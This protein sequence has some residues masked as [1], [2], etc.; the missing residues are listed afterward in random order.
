MAKKTKK[1]EDATS[2]AAKQ[3][4][5]AVSEF[6]S[7]NRHLLGFDNPTKAL[8]TTVREAVD[9]ALDAC[10]EAEILPTIEVQIDDLENNRYRVSITDNGPGILKNQLSR[11]FGQ[12]LYGSKFHRLKQS[13]GQQGIGISA[14]VMYGQMTTGQPSVVISKT[15]KG[16]PAHRM[17]LQ[18]DTKKNKAKVLTDDITTEAPWDERVSGTSISVILEGNYKGGKHGIDSYLRQTS[19]ANP[20]AEVIFISPKGERSEYPRV[21]QVLPV[22]PEEIKPHPYGVELGTLMR[23]LQDA[24]GQTVAAFLKSSFSRVSSQAATEICASADVSPRMSATSAG[25]TEVEELYNAIQ[26]TKLMAPPTNC[27][28]P[29]GE[30]AMVKG[31]Y[32]L[33]VEA[34][35]E[36]KERAEAELLVL[37]PDEDPADASDEGENT[38]NAK[39]EKLPGK[40]APSTKAAK[41][42]KDDSQLDLDF[43]EESDADEEAPAKPLSPAEQL[44]RIELDEDGALSSERDDFFV[45]AVTRP[46]AV[47]RGNPFQVE[48]GIFYGKGLPGDEMARVHRFANRVPL[49][50]Q[51]AACAM[52]KAVLTAP[53][54]NYEVQQSRG[55]MPSGPIVIMVHIASSWVP[56]TSESK[57]AIAHYEEILKELRLAIMECG[58]RLQKFLRR[59][60]R[61]ADEAKKRSYINKY[62]NPIGEAL[63]EI[64]GLSNKERDLTVDD[65]KVIL[66]QTRDNAGRKAS[67]KKS[68]G[69][70]K[71]KS[72][73][74]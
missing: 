40:R 34:K 41:K 32:W 13:R 53:W 38:E 54:R 51:A 18:I 7:K 31:L 50:Y 58:R 10:E 11:I 71:N 48:A 25:Q 19:L 15:G 70:K 49:Q 59:K 3:R 65:L 20:H 17:E 4:E 42:K 47:Y 27:L 28:S 6:F 45:T 22:E 69:K 73:A 21:I 16:R 23:M 26:R 24:K 61:E 36:A 66:E 9:N 5:I 30:E 39:V 64:L 62:L 72:K 60:R 67:K 8:L 55:A 56:Y 63:Q 37:R 12:L 29:I 33:F 74:A 2:M 46:P 1:R 44:A 57:E 14:A 43:T 35:R 52:Q 68:K